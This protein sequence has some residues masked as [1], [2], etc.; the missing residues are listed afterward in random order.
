MDGLQDVD[1]TD[2]TSR[3]SMRRGRLGVLPGLLT[4]LVHFVRQAGKGLGSLPYEYESQRRV[5]GLPLLSIN[6]GLDNPGG[7]MR[8][9]RGVLAIGNKAT[10]GVAIGLS[11][12]YGVVA[13]AP[14]AAGLMV[15][16]VA[17]VALAA[18]CVVG[19]GLLSVSVL[20]IGYLAVG[21]V[22][23]GT[24]A[25]GIVAVG[26]SVAAILGTGRA[27]STLFVP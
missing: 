5:L 6:L 18:V 20:A 15:L 8:A 7:K 2:A 9:A 24:K 23:V 27:A 25:V 13:L 16:S 17:G 3:L 26:K 22:A 12:A 1:A 10:G 14:F 19:L 11:L 21:I 4:A